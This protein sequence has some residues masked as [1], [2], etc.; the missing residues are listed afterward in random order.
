M[1]NVVSPV[2]ATVAIAAAAAAVDAN[3]FD[4]IT[5]LFICSIPLERTR[6]TARH[7]R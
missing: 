1:L 6:A 7:G 2:N 3:S 5:L 4:N